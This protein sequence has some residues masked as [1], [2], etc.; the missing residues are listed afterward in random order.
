MTIFE[1]NRLLVRHPEGKDFRD[2]LRIYNRAENMRYI[3]DGKHNWTIEELCGKIEL[4]NNDSESG[5]GI[6]I[7]KQKGT[8][9]V[10]GEAGLFNSFQDY[11]KLELGYIIDIA[12][13]G[14][15]Y[16][17]EICSGLVNFCFKQLNTETLIARM[18]AKN[19]ASVTLS[20]KCGMRR[21]EE[22]L[23]ENGEKFLVFQKRKS[24]TS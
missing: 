10:I 7:V 2:L 13:W 16:G 3:S 1:T 17:K 19:I 4:A 14:K 22:G 12:Y 8:G 18:Y 15:G 24:L 11:K 23:A 21:I 20:E 9:K 6:F 5:I